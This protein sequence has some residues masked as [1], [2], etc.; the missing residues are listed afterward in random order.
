[1]TGRVAE[2]HRSGLNPPSLSPPCPGLSGQLRID[3]SPGK[4]YDSPKM[5]APS[6]E[7][8]I[9]FLQKLQRL[10]REGSF[11]AS[12]KFALLQALCDLAVDH[13][14]DSGDSLRLP[15]QAIGQRFIQYYWRQTDPYTA[16]G[17]SATAERL[18]QNTDRQAKVVR[19]IA[20]VRGVQTL[21]D[22][23]NDKRAWPKLLNRVTRVVEQYPLQRLQT[24]GGERFD[25]LYQ[26]RQEAHEI[27]LRPGV[28]FCLRRFHGLIQ[29]L[30]RAAWLGFIGRIEA[31]KKLLGQPEELSDFLFGTERA[32]LSTCKHVLEQF[33]DCCFYCQVPL[34][35]RGVVDHFV[36][37]SLYSNDLGH[38]FV[39]TDP[40]CNGRKSNLLA[41]GRHLAHWER[42]LE[43]SGADLGTAFSA[44]GVVHDLRASQSVTKWAYE[45]AEA[46]DAQVWEGGGK[47]TVSLDANWRA[48]LVAPKPRV[49]MAAEE[50]TEWKQ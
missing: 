6:A 10:L 20:E 17:S 9:D 29:E 27:E 3:W 12:Y 44:A 39:L 24:I 21:P 49:L 50:K 1:M 18:L 36:P 15:T 11:T 8:Q 28:A 16:R 7:A 4:V 43:D 42:R 41:S 34:R 30:V 37:W 45:Q 38:N 13:G 25:F 2:F 32:D 14:D 19:L 46:S 48:L 33:E 31:N 23:Q 5:A 47:T 22:L 40:R 26:I 35:G